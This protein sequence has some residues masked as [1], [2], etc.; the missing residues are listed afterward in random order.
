MIGD[1]IKRNLFVFLFL[2]LFCMPHLKGYSQASVNVS[3]SEDVYRDLD[4]LVAHGLIQKIIVGQRPYSRKEIARLTKE[5]LSHLADWKNRTKNESSV[6]YVEEI[7]NRLQEDYHD[8][9]SES[10]SS[11]SWHP[12]D[13]ARFELLMTKSPSRLLGGNNGLGDIHTFVNPLLS[14]REGRHLI[15]GTNLSLETSH[16]AKV[17]KHFAFYASP[18]FQLAFSAEDL[19]SDNGVYIQDLNGKFSIKN[20]EV[21]VGRDHLIWGQGEHGGLLLS[22]NARGLDMIKI[23][24]DSPIFLPW[25]FKYLGPSKFSFFYSDLGPEQT[26]PHSYLTG[27]KLSFEPVSFFEVGTSILGESGG[28]GAPDGSFF[29][30]FRNVF[31]VVQFVTG[32]QKE[33]DNKMGGFDFRFRIPPLRGTEIYS[34]VIFDDTPGDDLKKFFWQDAG[35]LFGFY[36]PRLASDGRVDLRLEYKKTGVRYYRHHQFQTGWVLN[37]FVLGDHLGPDSLGFSVKSNW[38]VGQGD[39]LTA[40]AVFESRSADLYTSYRDPGLHLAKIFD[41]PDERRYRFSLGG[42][43]RLANFPL[44][45]G[46]GAGYEHVENF[47]F[48]SGKSLNN[49]LG[50]ISFQFH[51]DRWT[52]IR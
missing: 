45:F 12:I 32:S 34:E 2:A 33:I 48:V 31:P 11:S 20:F 8:E 16:W 47:N 1:H 27:F 26:F 38:D 4:K 13:K 30:R 14:E 41:G 28:E 6:R 43:H 52:K 36:I 25:V 24:N 18:R 7:L 15:E 46:W 42:G 37:D 10:S 21:E 19:S 44:R 35:Y 5:A 22:N 23:S 50:E 29:D 39:L 17:G 40:Q 9:L 3:I 51:F 49:F